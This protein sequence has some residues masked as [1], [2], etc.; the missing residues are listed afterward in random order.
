MVLIVDDKNKDK[1]IDDITAN[2]EFRKQYL[3][4]NWTWLSKEERTEKKQRLVMLE[5]NREKLVSSKL[6]RNLVRRRSLY[7]PIPQTEEEK[8][9]LLELIDSV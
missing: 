4:Q 8:K 1:D 2:I 9:K 7:D 5:N 3:L 6:G